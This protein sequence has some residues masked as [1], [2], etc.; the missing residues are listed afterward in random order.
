MNRLKATNSVAFADRDIAPLTGTPQYATDG[1]PQASIPP[2]IWPAYAYNMVQDEIIN[3]IVGAGLTPDD[4]NWAQLAAALGLGAGQSSIGTNPGFFT[5]PGGL[6][7]NFGTGQVVGA[8]A[9]ATISYVTGG[10]FTV[11]ALPA[12]WCLGGTSTSVTL[13]P[14]YLLVRGVGSSLNSITI[15][16]PN[17]SAVNV[18]WLVIGK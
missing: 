18:D 8:N 6:L 2:T 1:N 3:A 9:A 16:N 12:L 11:G 14:P 5:L 10:R 13:Y 15:S 4:T 17:G 7:V